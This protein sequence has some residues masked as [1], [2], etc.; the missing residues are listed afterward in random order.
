MIAV[1]AIAT[2][3]G[4]VLP[5]TYEGAFV[6]VAC[7]HSTRVS[8]PNEQ[9]LIEPIE[10]FEIDG[11]CGRRKGQTRFVQ[12][13]EESILIDTQLIELQVPPDKPRACVQ[14]DRI[15]CTAQPD[16]A[17]QFSRAARFPAN[18]IFSVRSQRKL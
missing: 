8:Q 4:R 6:C 1:D 12:R 17:G 5:R 14:P 3:I 13:V 9:E 7:G 18:A 16:I 10:C 11:G 15:P 2:K